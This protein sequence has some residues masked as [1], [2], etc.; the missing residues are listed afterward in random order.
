MKY[1]EERWV[2]PKNKYSIFTW[3]FGKYKPKIAH[4]ENCLPELEI[5]YGFSKFPGFCNR[6]GSISR[7]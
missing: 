4:S 2:L 7:D 6:V 3:C 1:D 5:Q